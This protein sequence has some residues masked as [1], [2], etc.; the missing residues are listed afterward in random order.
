MIMLTATPISNGPNDLKNQLRLFP[1][2]KLSNVPP[3]GNTTLDEY[4]KKVMVDGKITAE[5]AARIRELLRHVLVRRTRTHI[6]DKYAKQDE[7]G[8]YLESGG[9]KKYFP[10]RQLHNPEE[11]D[12]DMVYSSSFDAIQR[13]IGN[14]KLARYAPGNYVKE[15][16]L[17][18]G[19][20]RVQEIQ[21]SCQHN[22]ATVR[23]CED[24]T[25]Q[26]DGEQHSGI[27]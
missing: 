24:I 5:G 19:K 11:Y 17:G 21:G 13:Y 3:L 20:A 22:T 23:Y 15:E 8:Y 27:F 10:K 25:P 4:F 16:Y 2:G 1:A 26:E 6:M 12:A 7:R 14:L 9:E 18:R